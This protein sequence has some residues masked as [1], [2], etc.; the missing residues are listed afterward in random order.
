LRATGLTVK[1]CPIF[2]LRVLQK[3]FEG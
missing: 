2:K 3:I 1:Y